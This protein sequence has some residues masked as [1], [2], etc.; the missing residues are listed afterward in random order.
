MSNCEQTVEVLANG[1]TIEVV[2]IDSVPSTQID[3]KSNVI[4]VIKS[5][6]EITVEASPK[7]EVID[8]HTVT[9][10]DPGPQGKDGKEGK[11]GIRGVAGPIGPEGREG[12]EGKRGFTG[13]AGND[14]PIVAGPPG[15]QGPE[16]KEGKRGFPGADGIGKRGIPGPQGRDG[17]DGSRGVRGFPGAPGSFGGQGNP[18]TPGPPGD[19]DSELLLELVQPLLNEASLIPIAEIRKEIKALPGKIQGLFL[20]DL[21]GEDVTEMNWSAGTD[22]GD[23]HFVGSVTTVSMISD[24][25]Y[26]SYKTT[27]GMITKVSNSM[28]AIRQEQQVT[29][30]AGRATA[31][32]LTTFVAQTGTNIGALQQR[33]EVTTTQ[34]YAT[35]LSLTQ[36][37]ALTETSLAQ[38][39]ERIEV[40]ADEQESS[41]I[42]MNEYIASSDSKF[43][44]IGTKLTNIDG[45]LQVVDNRF[46]VVDGQVIDLNTG[47]ITTNQNLNIVDGKVV[48]VN[49]RV[50]ATNQEVQLAQ[51]NIALV[52]NTVSVHSDELSAQA[53]Q[54]NILSTKVGDQTTDILELYQLVNDAGTGELKANYQ[55]KAQVTQGDKVVLTG[56]ALGASI[57]ENGSYRSEILF[58]ADT[59]GFLTKNGGSIHQP[60]VFDVANDTARL[61]NV[62]IGTASIG[63]A[64]F[65]DWLESDAKGPGNIPVLR[66]NF[67]TGEIQINSTAA[68]GGRLTLNNSVIQV[69]DSAN[70]LRVR[71]GIW[72]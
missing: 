50:D 30:E 14:A 13:A 15:V 29:A 32:Q 38:F 66:L 72:A 71:M 8:V 2:T 39:T 63:S 51:Q 40:I 11:Q 9:K 49:G 31:S 47:L 54:L 48:T 27:T 62:F 7:S 67:R 24:K 44:S 23:D 68:G 37:S 20:G 52:R 69:F 64:K 17:P 18:G 42:A 3:G 19:I 65:T 46:S 57:G 33:L 34:T 10:G 28:A 60:F 1:S 61:N 58:M 26:S 36:L 12:A 22:D 21:A 25:D 35:A 5:G 41:V 43:T 53:N 55:L 16:G 59:I 56:M 4:E 6:T 45:S 70:Q